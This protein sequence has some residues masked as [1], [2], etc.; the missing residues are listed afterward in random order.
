MLR[1]GDFALTW[2]ESL[3]WDERINRLWFVDCAAQTLH[4]LDGGEPPLHTMT[5]PSLP[6]G[7]ALTDGNEIVVCLDG[8]LHVV[9]VDAERVELLA[10]YPDGMHG[11][12]NDMDADGAGN[13]VTGTLNLAP[14]PGAYWWWSSSD[15]WRLLEDGIGNANGPVV[16]DHTLVFADTHAAAVFAYDYDAAAGTVSNRRTISDHGALGEGGVPDGATIDDRDGVWSCVLNVGTLARITLDGTVDR[17][18]DVPVRY[19]SDVAFGGSALDRM[20]VTSI[21][22]DLGGGD[23]GDAAG[24][25]LAFD[26]VAVGRPALRVRL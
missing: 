16:V 7:V 4:W 22:V 26:G 14:A 6:T 8:G 25:L 19:P 24:Q 3:R 1:V 2:G 17:T 20:F 12:A 23:P 10:P 11:R 9:D 13:L 18:L 15:G 5:L 21:A